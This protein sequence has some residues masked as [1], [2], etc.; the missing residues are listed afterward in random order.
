MIIDH[1]KVIFKAVRAHGPGGQNAN[2]RSTRVQLWV[3]IGDLPITDAQKKV[4]REKLWHHVNRDDEVWVADEEERLQGRN[5]DKALAHLNSLIEVALRVP[6]PRI[7]T[8]KPRNA[9]DVR[10][11][12][13][14]IK[15]AKKQSRRAS[16]KATA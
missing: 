12:A 7:P 2:R 5:R 1:Q 4:L 16:H 15:S 11:R 9:E 10:I 14:K 6:P 13:K 8:E 3:R